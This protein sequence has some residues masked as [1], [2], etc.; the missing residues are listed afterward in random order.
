[1]ISTTAAAITDDCTQG[2]VCVLL[3]DF[4]VS[5]C[6]QAGKPVTAWKSE[7]EFLYAADL[8]GR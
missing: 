4:S 5:S 1:M 2:T 8:I 6:A 3:W 7:I